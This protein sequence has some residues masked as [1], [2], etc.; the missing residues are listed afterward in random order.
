MSGH[1]TGAGVGDWSTAAFPA[2]SSKQVTSPEMLRGMSIQAGQLRLEERARRVSAALEEG[3][4]VVGPW[5]GK[6][7]HKSLD[8]RM[9]G[10]KSQ[11]RMSCSI[12]M[13]H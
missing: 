2:D 4:G 8:G 3:G 13:S 12:V 5:C 6:G 7:T 10:V 9:C 11:S 1:D